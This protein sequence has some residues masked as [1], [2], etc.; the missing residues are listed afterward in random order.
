MM[1][2]KNILKEREINI[3]PD[4]NNNEYKEIDEREALLIQSRLLVE[5][6]EKSNETFLH[7]QRNSNIVAIVSLGVAMLSIIFVLLCIVAN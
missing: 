1:K 4:N 7:S 3:R 6:F 5:A 2:G